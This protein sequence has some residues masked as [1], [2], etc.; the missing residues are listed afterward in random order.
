MKNLFLKVFMKFFPD[1]KKYELL[2]NLI[3]LY[4]KAGKK[5]SYM[6]DVY[7]KRKFNNTVPWYDHR[8]DW[9]SGPGYWGWAER[10]FIGL[11]VIKKGDRVLDLCCGDGIYSGLFFSNR[12]SLVHGI[13]ISDEAVAIAKR[14]E[15]DKFRVFKGDV[16]KD[17]FPERKYDVIFLFT[18][19]QYFEPEQ[20]K[21]LLKKI[22]DHLGRMFLGSVSIGPIRQR[23]VRNTFLSEEELKDFLSPFFRKIEIEKSLW[24]D[25]VFFFCYK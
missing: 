24:R 4:I 12:A 13:D 9:A 8:F 23:A 18:S 6:Y 17:P 5:I 10:G 15:N 1:N 20:G 7:W 2:D 14:Y 25:E 16:I 19:I 21:I 3:E 22:S 11:K